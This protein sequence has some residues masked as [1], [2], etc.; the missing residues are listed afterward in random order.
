MLFD[1]HVGSFKSVDRRSRDW[2]NGL[3]PLYEK[4]QR[5]TEAIKRIKGER[6]VRE[7]K[8]FSLTITVND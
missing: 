3:M 5:S 7:V 6:A 8:L 1:K 4:M 2:T